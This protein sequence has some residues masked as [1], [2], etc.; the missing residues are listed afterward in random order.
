MSAWRRAALGCLPS[1]HR[2]AIERNEDVGMLWVDLWLAFTEAHLEPVDE[3]TIRGVYEFAGWCVGESHNDDIQTT[4]ALHFYEHLPT[5][6]RVRE[7][8]PEHMTRQEF[9]GFTD[10]FKYHLSP[11]EHDEFVEDF[12]RQRRLLDRHAARKGTSHGGNGEPSK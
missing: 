11:E 6:K 3:E 9:L 5:D 2:E 12:L 7:R 1:R 10:V 4:A 8:L